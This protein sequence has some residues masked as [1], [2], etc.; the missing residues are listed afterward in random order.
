MLRLL[1]FPPL[2]ETPDGAI[3]G[4]EVPDFFCE[5]T[6]H[7][8]DTSV[9]E[10]VCVRCGMVRNYAMV[11]SSMRMLR[12][13]GPGRAERYN[14]GS[15]TVR[16]LSGYTDGTGAPI[17]STRR[18]ELILLGRRAKVP[19]R[20]RGEHPKT[21][22]AEDET[23]ETI[24]G[25]MNIPPL[26]CDQAFH[27][28]KRADDAGLLGSVRIEERVA[29]ALY[30]VLR[31]KAWD[32]AVRM[33]EILAA[34]GVRVDHTVGKGHYRETRSPVATW[35]MTP[36]KHSAFKVKLRL[37]RAF[38]IAE[39]PLT[40]VS[41]LRRHADEVGLTREEREMC[42]EL[43]RILDTERGMGAQPW[44]LAAVAIYLVVNRNQMSGQAPRKSQ[45]EVGRVTGVSGMTV[46]SVRNQVLYDRD[47]PGRAEAVRAILRGRPG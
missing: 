9:S 45:A 5:P 29:A 6:Q 39:K 18:H 7:Q 36:A 12:L 22:H 15:S 43:L 14:D 34:A 32:V 44:S 23:L 26:A 16:D 46:R 31:S 8:I 3:T 13:P 11:T 37:Q 33:R 42:E 25:A 24:A 2:P 41:Y 10:E 19:A 1:P 4:P 28:L 30:T 35:S 38:R 17:R 47:H 27:L 40:S 20:L 21:L